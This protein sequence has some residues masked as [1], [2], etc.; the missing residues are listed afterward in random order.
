LAS[1][2]Q[3][4]ISE[5]QEC[6]AKLV[7]LFEGAQELGGKSRELCT[8]EAALKAVE[9]RIQELRA[10]NAKKRRSSHPMKRA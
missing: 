1:D 5:L 10:L 9:E 3:P 4:T 8:G 7:R 6:R 2:D